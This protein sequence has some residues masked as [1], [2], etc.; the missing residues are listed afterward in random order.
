[1]DEAQRCR[2]EASDEFELR[3]LAER[4]PDAVAVE[5]VRYAAR[6]LEALA[7]EGD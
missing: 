5:L 4:D 1:M 6:V 3:V 7:G 2:E